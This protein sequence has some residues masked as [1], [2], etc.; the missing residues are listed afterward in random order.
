MPLPPPPP[1]ITLIT[2]ADVWLDDGRLGVAKPGQA[3][4][5]RGSRIASVGP[6][7]RLAAQYPKATRIVLN[8]GT[9][10]PAFTEGHAHV[11]SL[12][13]TRSE[14]VLG[15]AADSAD[16]AAR[17]KAWAQLHR[18][19][20]VLGRGWDQNR[21]PGKGFPTASDLDSS[22]GS[23]PAMLT[24]VDGHAI[25]VNSAALRLAGI[26][27]GTPDPEGGR[28]LRDEKGKPTGVLVDLAMDLVGKIVPGPSDAE[29]REHLLE[30]LGEL[31]G[32][33]FAAVADM[34]IGRGDLAVYRALES[35]GALPIRVFAYLD[36]DSELML[37]ELKRPRA[38]TTSFF[39]IQGVKFYMDGALGSRGARLLQPYADEPGSRGLWV[40]PPG[41]VRRDV[42]ITMKAGYQ[43]AIHAIGDAGNREALNLLEAAMGSSRTLPPRIEHAQIVAPEDTPRFGALGLIASVQPVHCTSDHPWTPARLGPER[44]HEAYPWREFLKGGAV[45]AFGSDT[46]IEDANPYVALAAAETRE[47]ESGD[48]PG[49]FLPDQRLTREEAIRAYTLGN[50]KALGRKDMGRIKTGGVADLLWLDARILALTPSQLRRLR[51]GRLW[52]NGQEV[53]LAS[54]SPAR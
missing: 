7:K 44:V 17:V 51:P 28:I 6:E 4:A 15:G 52:V 41:T 39:Q 24:R 33:G 50:A 32:D 35:E 31:Q 48:P 30:A 8:G 5:L 19:G 43:P 49:G 34:G 3:V 29:R 26:S 45:L 27:E 18:S 23:R 36:H 40:T 46:P 54:S 10:L 1:A 12:G 25:W 47:D 53:K 2:G 14:A 37:K 20:W 16:A 38:K 11:G 13:A 21:W 9:L 42:A 22:T